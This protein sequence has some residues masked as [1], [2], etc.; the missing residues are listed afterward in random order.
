MK[1]KL[2][3]TT[4]GSLMMSVLL[5]QAEDA[6]PAASSP[7]T[8][9]PA[10][11]EV[12]PVAPATQVA[13]AGTPAAAP[14]AEV[15]PAETAPTEAKPAEAAPAEAAPAEAKPAAAADAPATQGG[16]M[17]LIS[18]SETPLLDAIR[19][20][21]RRGGINLIIDPKVAYGQPDP[22]KPG[23]TLPQP[24][25]DIRWENVTPE[26]ALNA[27]LTTYGLQAIEDPK[28]KITR[29]TVKDPAAP[30]PIITRTFQLS[31][32]G[33]SNVLGAVTASLSDKRSKVVADTRTSQ[34]IVVATE[35]ELVEVEK[36]VG[37]LDTKTK[38]VLI[39]SKIIETTVN[40]KTVK[41]VD[42][43][44]TLSSHRLGYG[45]NNQMKPVSDEVSTQAPLSDQWPRMIMEGGSFN[46]ATAFLNADGLNLT[47]SYLNTHN[48]SRVVSEPRMV[49]LDNQKA[50]ID[51]GLLFPIVNTSA[52][53][54]NTAGGSQIAYTNLTVSLDVTPRIAA[55]EQVELKISQSIVR[56][57]PLIPS[58]VGGVENEVNSFFTRQAHT[59][60][61]V[62]SAHTLVLGGLISDE[63]TTAN[64]KVP[65]LGDIPVLGSLFRKDSKERN[66]NNLLI[67]ITPTIVA[68]TD[69]Q[70][71]ST[72]FLKTKAETAEEPEWNSWDSGKPRDWSKGKGF[73][74][75]TK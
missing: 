16:G 15:K 72:S 70:A 51:V 55:N 36:L 50:T 33:P 22:A 52:G 13:D 24:T 39:E 29:I 58:T 64:T 45:N 31:Y 46:P 20:L 25:V 5:A 27:L 17:E 74:G 7:A 42:W 6:T 34:I 71:A 28:I 63:N 49:T 69:Y 18:I 44:G 68:D 41:G 23:A 43:S 12:Q 59:A 73:N 30:D 26:Q 9:A 47:L 62:P 38:Q 10:T 61:L 14:A 57:G 48:D 21:A 53:T 65:I 3:L 4:L 75:P 54:A 32:A 67:F 2:V 56:L 1:A 60:V 8:P 11:A 37:K 19:M 66:K 40:P 35:K